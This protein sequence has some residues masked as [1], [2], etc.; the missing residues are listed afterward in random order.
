MAS[1]N[2]VILIGNLGADP[3]A[4]DTGSGDRWCSIRIATTEKWTDKHGDKQE[5]T[6]WHRVVFFRKLAEIAEKYLEKGSPVYIEGKLKTRKYTDKN[7][8]DK[9]QTEVWADSMQL[10]G[11]GGGN[12]SRDRDDDRGRGR[13]R[14]DDR[15]SRGRGRDD[16]YQEPPRKQKPKPSFEDLGG[17]IPF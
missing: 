8:D 15:G 14:N 3:D 2:K 6:E 9:Y 5:Q 17:D 16:D 1:V 10:L 7:G 11:Q 12:K 4:G 13:D